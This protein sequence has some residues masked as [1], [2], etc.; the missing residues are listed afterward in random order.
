MFSRMKT[1]S[2]FLTVIATVLSIGCD[3]VPA[4]YPPNPGDGVE[5]IP[6]SAAVSECGGFAQKTFALTDASQDPIETN[7]CDAEVIDWQYDAESGALTVT[8]HR[9]ILNC[10]GD[11]GI[12]IKQV[13]DG[14]YVITETDAPMALENG[15][16][17][18]CNCMCV[19]DFELE[20]QDIPQEDIAVRLILDVTDA[21]NEV[22]VYDG[23]LNLTSSSFGSIVIEDDKDASIWCDGAK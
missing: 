9:V 3:D 18:R 8:D 11:H 16:A 14:T 10:C 17:S 22:I 23:V 5:A 15:E 2:L 13:E 20:A 1:K 12:S 19:F 6:Q 21:D 7:Y 4:H